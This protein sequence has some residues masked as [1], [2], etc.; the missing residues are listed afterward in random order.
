MANS[1]P[2]LP[3]VHGH[4]YCSGEHGTYNGASTTSPA[5]MKTVAMPSAAV[6]NPISWPLVPFCRLHH[7]YSPCL[8]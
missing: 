3:A 1:L 8:A 7:G 2:D 5:Q 4:A 6:E